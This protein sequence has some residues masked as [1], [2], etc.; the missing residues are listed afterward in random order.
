[1]TEEELFCKLFPD[2]AVNGKLYMTV[3]GVVLYEIER[4]E[5]KE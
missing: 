2:Y 5:I 1:M 4:T 3:G